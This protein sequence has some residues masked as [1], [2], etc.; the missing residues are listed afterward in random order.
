MRYSE[1]TSELTQSF[2]LPLGTRAIIELTRLKFVNER[3]LKRE[4]VQMKPPRV[5]TMK[6]YGVKIYNEVKLLLG[7]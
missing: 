6:Y 4:K 3:E 2:E 5:T 1:L 7:L